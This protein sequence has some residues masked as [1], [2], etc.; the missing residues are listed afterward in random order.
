MSQKLNLILG[1]AIAGLLFSANPL[2]ATLLTDPSF[3]DA[4]LFVDD[5]NGVGAWNPFAGGGTSELD[6]TMPFTGASAVKLN[7]DGANGFAGFFQ[8]VPVMPGDML[9]WTVYT[10]ETTGQNGAGIEMR[11]EWFDGMGNGLGATPNNTPA[12]LGSTYELFGFTDTA[13][14][15]ATVGR[16]VFAIQTFGA[17][18]PQMVFVDDASAQIVPVPEPSSLVLLGLGG[19]AL[20]RRRKK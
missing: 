9:E 10:K 2:F 12:S 20:I 3:E 8:D 6:T 13:P 15:G 5:G 7:L 4:S 1:F 11:I 16:V 17:A 19:L 14:A 18:A